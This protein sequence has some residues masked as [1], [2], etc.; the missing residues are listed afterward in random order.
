MYKEKKSL[1]KIAMKSLKRDIE[2]HIDVVELM[3]PVQLGESPSQN[4]SHKSDFTCKT[5]KIPDLPVLCC[6]VLCC[7][8]QA[9]TRPT[10]MR[11]SA[12]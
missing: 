4:M 8:V 2:L 10:R 12:S 3:C 7:A 9:A 6:A 5:P 11:V 1:F